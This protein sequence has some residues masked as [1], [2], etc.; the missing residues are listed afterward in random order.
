V[1]PLDARGEW[2]PPLVASLRAFAPID[3]DRVFLLGHSMG[4]R[5]GVRA[6]VRSPGLFRAIALFGCGIEPA[7][8]DRVA[9]VPVH[10]FCGIEDA[11]YIAMNDETARH[12]AARGIAAFAY[13][14]VEG[15]GHVEVGQLSMEEIFDRLAA[16]R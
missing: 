4:G 2:V 5:F 8:L 9:P 3:R 16:A 7:E 11:R 15:G 12:A 10:V 13:A 6:A 1:R 14:R